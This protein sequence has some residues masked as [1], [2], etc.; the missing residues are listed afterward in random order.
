MASPWWLF[1]ASLISTLPGVYADDARISPIAEAPGWQLD[2]LMHLQ[3]TAPE[4]DAL[5]LTYSVYPLTEHAGLNQTDRSV[6]LEPPCRW[7]ASESWPLTRYSPSGSA[8]AWSL[9]RWH[10]MPIA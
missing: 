6:R 1:L 9:P 5:Q 2:S 3:L 4:T 8:E 7:F 10:R